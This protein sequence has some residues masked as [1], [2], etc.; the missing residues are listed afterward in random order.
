[1]P[2][3]RDDRQQARTAALTHAARV[4][5][6]QDARATTVRGSRGPRV[7]AP[8]QEH[9]TGHSTALGRAAKYLRKGAAGDAHALGVAGN[10]LFDPNSSLNRSRP[11]RGANRLGTNA[12]NVLEKG[13]TKD[14][15]YGSS[16]A[17]SGS[18]GGVGFSPNFYKDHGRKSHPADFG[19]LPGKHAVGSGL[20]DFADNTIY[21]PAGIYNLA[22]N[23]KRTLPAVGRSVISDFQ[24]PG[25]HWDRTAQDVLALLTAGAS[26]AGRAGA[27][28]GA[29]REG[30]SAGEALGA[31]L[32]RPT[33]GLRLIKHDG[34]TSVALNSNNPVV[35]PFQ[36]G[37][38]RAAGLH[39]GGRT[40][41]D[42]SGLAATR[43]AWAAHR[44][45]VHSERANTLMDNVAAATPTTR[46]ER[47]LGKPV[48]AT[49]PRG[50]TFGGKTGRVGLQPVR[51]LNRASRAAILY[52][53]LGYLPT[54]LVGQEW[55]ALT[56][57]GLLSPLRR[58]QQGATGL[59]RKLS[60]VG[61]SRLNEL[62]GTGMVRSSQT[63]RGRAIPILSHV[64]QAVDAVD[65]GFS[66]LYGGVL[67][68]PYRRAALVHELRRQGIKGHKETE[69]ALQDLAQWRHEHPKLVPQGNTHRSNELPS[70]LRREANARKGLEA[71]LRS[72]Q[73]MINYDALGP[74]GK[75]AKDFAFF[76]PWLK[77][78][79]LFLG[80]YLRDNPIQAAIYSQLGAQG[81]KVERKALGKQPSFAEGDFKVGERN[82]PGL[83]RVPLV[84]N[85]SSAAINTQPVEI[86]KTLAAVAGLT[87]TTPGNDVPG[88]LQPTL[89]SSL[90]ALTHKD[91]FTGHTLPASQG[92]PEI[93]GRQFIGQIPLYTTLYKGGA[94]HGLGIGPQPKSENPR[95][96]LFPR[97]SLD[98]T[99]Q[100]TFSG[101]APTPENPVV[102]QSRQRAEE[103]SGV[104]KKGGLDLRARYFGDDLMKKLN[105]LAQA[106]HFKTLPEVM[107][108]GINRNKAVQV[109]ALDIA[110]HYPQAVGQHGTLTS[111]G[112]LAA[113][114]AAYFVS[115]KASPQAVDLVV[116]AITSNPEAY[117]TWN[118]RLMGTKSQP[119]PVA[120]WLTPWRQTRGFA[121]KLN[122]ATSKYPYA[123]GGAPVT[124][125]R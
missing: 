9:S 43:E 111:S 12:V 57:E 97:N 102:Q 49:E 52:G 109:A 5:A 31:G 91:P 30:G 6:H 121:K 29:L 17:G 40:P 124:V 38:D 54:N 92:W 63:A 21:A 114:T 76:A 125:P 70:V 56:H 105:T 115:L 34:E 1:M 61:N 85:P 24:H 11:L 119:G 113:K 19:F 41:D 88:Y 18:L 89:Y 77:G 122:A 36:R 75:K 3:T 53:K 47:L 74:F 107:A 110:K 90:A 16:A 71:G 103:V 87:P 117:K 37:L 46:R 95:Y 28:A 78:S 35:R 60:P 25:R 27:V 48:E 20:N 82:V 116:K 13:L 66:G 44:F 50:Q 7:V 120:A 112:S 23:P 59:R 42:L 106:D 14:N 100:F 94:L 86:G 98:R 32:R 81:S 69:L 8:S 83:G 80:H 84:V 67:D 55:L 79:S 62:A 64:E 65:R 104:S 45:R 4:H 123:N 10:Y 51:V 22:T 101:L 33:G 15:G 26:T 93:F 58:T 72:N 96:T 39:K 99:L 118:H 68:T 108:A 2:V 73:A